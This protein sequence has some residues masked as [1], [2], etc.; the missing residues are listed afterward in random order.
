MI[1]YKKAISRF[2]IIDKGGV[3]VPFAVNAF[4]EKFIQTMTGKDI[5]LKARQCGFSSLLLAIFCVDFLTKENSRSVIIS[6]DSP[7]AQRLLDRAKYFLSSIERDGYKI[8]LKYNSR[9]EMANS[10]K[11]SSLYIGAAGNR[12]FGRGDT[13]NNLLLSEF[14]FYDDPQSMLASVLQALVPGGRVVIETTANGYNYF[15]DFWQKSK[16]GET[17]FAP[18]FFGN[19]FYSPQ[20]FGREEKRI[21]RPLPAGVPVN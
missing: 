5:I 10:A 9:V 3:S 20:F 18:H 12:S 17:G 1:D 21:R 4:Q 6:H 11:N 13:L 8:D 19:D 14:A 15:E 7:S 2:Q 16:A